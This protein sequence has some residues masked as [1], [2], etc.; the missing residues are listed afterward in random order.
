[1]DTVELSYMTAAMHP[2]YDHTFKVRIADINGYPGNFT[3]M[4]TV[5]SPN[6]GR[7][8]AGGAHCTHHECFVSILIESNAADL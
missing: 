1:M 2:G 4:V 7:C 5:L 3:Q 6:P 8:T